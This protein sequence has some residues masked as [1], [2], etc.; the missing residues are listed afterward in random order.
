MNVSPSSSKILLH[1][2]SVSHSTSQYAFRADIDQAGVQVVQLSI[3]ESDG[4]E[5]TGIYEL[6]LNT[7]MDH[8]LNQPEEAVAFHGTD[9]K[10]IAGY[11]AGVFNVSFIIFPLSEPLQA[12]W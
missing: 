1:G 10:M 4:V 9:D 8:E 11:S 2:S 5:V 7:H 12:K 3:S 6:W